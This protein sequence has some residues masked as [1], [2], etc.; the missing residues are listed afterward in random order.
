MKKAL[1]GILILGVATLATTYFIINY[2]GSGNNQNGEK[3]AKLTFPYPDSSNKQQIALGQSL[4]NNQCA[5][6]HGE[7]LEGEPNWRS[8]LADGSLPAPPHDENGHTW[9]HPDSVLFRITKYGGASVAPE[10]FNSRMPA[11]EE[12]LSDEDISATLAFIKSKWPKNIR[13]RQQ[14]ITEKSNYTNAP[15]IDPS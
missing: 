14:Q 10:G 7:N 3:K 11:F 9:H 1:S 4:Y 12:T 13:M 5:S 8:P 2:N 15:N 6:C